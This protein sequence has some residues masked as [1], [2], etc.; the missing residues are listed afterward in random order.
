[1]AAKNQPSDEIL[2][3][4][5]KRPA[6]RQDALRR[7]LTKPFLKTDEDEC[8]ELLKSAHGI[9]TTKL[10]ANP[11]DAKHLPVRSS[12]ATSL[13]LVAID[14]IANVNRL[15]KDAALSLAT[16][17][18]TIIYGDNGSGKSG[19]VRILKKACRSR[20][21]EEILP[22]VF[23]NKK[24]NSPASARFTVEEGATKLA[25]IGWLDDGKSSADALGR[26]SIFDSK[27]ASVHVDGENRIEVVPHNLDC[28]ERLAHVCDRLRTRLKEESDGL[29]KQLAGALPEAP[30]GTAAE[31]FKAALSKKNEGDL[32]AACK[33]SEANQ[34]GL[35]ELTGMLKDPYAEAQ[36]CERI[37]TACKEFA[38][39]LQL[40]S[41]ALSDSKIAE[42]AALRKSAQELRG[43]SNA[44][45]AAAFAAEALRG[46]G[47]E[48]WRAMFDAARAYS[49]QHAYPGEPFPRADADARCVLCQ[50]S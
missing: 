24:A 19:F 33:F 21:D 10:I 18:L 48:P 37:S 27:C 9:A 8:L 44:S 35:A 29:E 22:D 32:T 12:S 50:Q 3:W 28:F 11:L 16:D 2:A 39:Q 34:K 47:E 25:P 31:T 5:K 30:K 4:A 49:E 17:G 7:I 20:D 15:A 13:R 6:W 23:A 26:F 42:I 43:Q 45:A 46:V 40:A 38:D 14:D 41:T 36:K 1:M